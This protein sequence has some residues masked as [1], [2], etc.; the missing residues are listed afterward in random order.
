VARLV[1]LSHVIEAGMVTYPGLPGVVVDGEGAVGPD[2][3]AG[4]DV[5]GAAVLV[6]TGWDRHFGAERYGDPSHPHLTGAAAEHLVA[7]GARLVGI[8]SVNIDGTT[9]GERPVHT[10]AP[11]THR[12]G[13]RFRPFWPEIAPRTTTRGPG[14]VS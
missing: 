7:E 11:Q 13:G 3:F 5:A 8:D 2:V 10:E 1:D 6:R 9:T 14:P 12:T 4:V